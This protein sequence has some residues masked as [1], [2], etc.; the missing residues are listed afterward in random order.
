MHV[1]RLWNTHKLYARRHC[2]DGA[3][4]YNPSL[5]NPSPVFA[6]VLVLA[7]L[8]STI[9][10]RGVR[11]L[12]HRGRRTG[13]MTLSFQYS[14]THLGS[15]QTRSKIVEGAGGLVYLPSCIC[16]AATMEPKRYSSESAQAKIELGTG[17]VGFPMTD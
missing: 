10:P 17:I 4:D 7:R 15:W 12:R 8:E 1:F 5:F 9:G 13:T 3:V 16:W 6:Q 2:L 14:R 11:V